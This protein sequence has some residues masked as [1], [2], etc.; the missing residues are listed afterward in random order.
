MLFSLTGVKRTFRNLRAGSDFVESWKTAGIQ[1]I[2]RG[3]V[4]LS[5]NTLIEE[6][7]FP[8]RSGLGLFFD[9]GELERMAEQREKDGS[10][11]DFRG[12][13]PL[14][15]DLLDFSIDVAAGRI[16]LTFTPLPKDDFDFLLGAMKKWK[17]RIRQER[18]AAWEASMHQVIGS[19]AIPA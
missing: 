15:L 10:S 17:E 4:L 3:A 2:L 6:V 8:G 1:E 5:L 16:S 7:S 12:G 19:P 14:H 11:P 9:Y 13:S 18:L